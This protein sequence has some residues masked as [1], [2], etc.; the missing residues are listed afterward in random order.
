M[1]T[2]FPED[3]KSVNW[4]RTF[5]FFSPSFVVLSP[6]FLSY[7]CRLAPSRNTGELAAILLHVSDCFG[8]ILV[9]WTVFIL[10]RLPP[11]CFRRYFSS[12]LHVNLPYANNC[13][14][15]S[16]SIIFLQTLIKS[17]LFILN[18]HNLHKSNGSKRYASGHNFARQIFYSDKLYFPLG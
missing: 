7:F 17:I 16:L 6:Y 12:T 4:L 14:H 1:L 13:I 2:Q 11:G 5:L 18:P 3:H 15:N 9:F 10:S 8:L